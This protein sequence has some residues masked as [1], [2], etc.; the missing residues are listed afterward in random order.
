MTA[1]EIHQWREPAAGRGGEGG[2]ERSGEAC[3]GQQR[4]G[5]EKGVRFRGRLANGSSGLTAD[6]RRWRPELTGGR[7][8]NPEPLSWLAILVLSASPGLFSHTYK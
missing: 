6:G 1:P 4:H 2:A 8:G 7:S 3:I 5:A